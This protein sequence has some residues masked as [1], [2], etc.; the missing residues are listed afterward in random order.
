MNRTMKDEGL[1][2][3]PQ[4]QQQQLQR[5]VKVDTKLSASLS[6]VATVA[7]GTDTA[8]AVTVSPV[9]S[10]SLPN[11]FVSKKSRSFKRFQQWRMSRASKAALISSES[12]DESDPH[13]KEGSSISSS[14]SDL[15]YRQNRN[16]DSK[17][18]KEA[19][20]KLSKSLERIGFM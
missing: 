15:G 6:T 4:Q 12:D 19:D 9:L 11:A 18:Q 10:Q 2:S 8:A 5:P 20:S 14:S 1:T 13:V 16:E 3:P 7:F 17:H